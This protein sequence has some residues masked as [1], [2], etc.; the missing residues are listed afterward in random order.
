[1]ATFAAA[2]ARS[3]SAAEP[4]AEF[5]TG[6][7]RISS[8]CAEGSASTTSI[9]AGMQRPRLRCWRR[10]SPDRVT[11]CAGSSL[12]APPCTY[13][14][15]RGWHA[16]KAHCRSEKTTCGSNATKRGNWQLLVGRASSPTGWTSSTASPEAGRRRWPSRSKVRAIVIPTDS[17][18]QRPR[19]RAAQVF[20]RDV[21]LART[22]CRCPR[23]FR[24]GRCARDNR[25][26]SQHG[27]IH[28]S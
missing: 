24:G 13:R 25:C 9:S 2:R 28:R 11:P 17:S 23:R 3:R 12:L 6:C 19:T 21:A 10:S 20:A 7:V 1:M 26:T 16:A 5:A 14:S 27:N 4:T 8:A 18:V 22:R 15:R